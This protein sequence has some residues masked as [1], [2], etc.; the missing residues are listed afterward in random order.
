MIIFFKVVDMN[1]TSLLLTT[2]LAED[3]T[4]MKWCNYWDQVII[5]ISFIMMYFSSYPNHHFLQHLFHRLFQRYRFLS[6][7]NFFQLI[8]HGAIPFAVLAVANFR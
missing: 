1:G 8:I 6:H 5:N 2:D 3:K 4:Y 7:C